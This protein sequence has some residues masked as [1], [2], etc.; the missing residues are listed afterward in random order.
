M[1]PGVDPL[2]HE[3]HVQTVRLR[4]S[5]HMGAGDRYCSF[6]F[7]VALWVKWRRRLTFQNISAKQTVDNTQYTTNENVDR[8]TTDIRPTTDMPPTVHRN[9]TVEVSAECRPTYQPSTD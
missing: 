8:Y 5:A 9:V 6:P 2:S 3:S 1:R 7:P 4:R